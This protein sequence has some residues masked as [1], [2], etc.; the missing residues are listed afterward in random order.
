[1]KNPFIDMPYLPEFDRM[2]PEA[3][4]EAFA[5]LIP[6]TS[7]KFDEMEK[8]FTP[9]W[10]GLIQRL[11][12]ITDPLGMAWSMFQHLKSVVDNDGW[13]E[14]DTTFRPQIIE[15]YQKISQ[16]QALYNGYLTLQEADRKG[17]TLNATRRRILGKAI[18]DAE[19]SGVGLPPDKQARMNEVSLK[20]STCS[21]TFSNHVLDATKAFSLTVTDPAIVEGLPESLKAIT[22]Q[23]AAEEGQAGD[24][25]KGPWKITLDG[26]VMRPFM[27]YCRDRD[28]REKIL[29]AAATR[30]SSGEL[31]NSGL[32]E[33][34]IKLRTEEAQILGFPNYAALNLS[35]KMAKNVETVDKLI[36]DLADASQEA[37]N[38]ETDELT[39]FAQANGFPEKEL[40]NWDMAYWAERQRETLYAY[41]EEE[42]SRYFPLPHVL[43][44]L[45]QLAERLFNIRISQADGE[46][47]VW[48][49]DVHFFRVADHDGT[50]LA[51]FYLDPY[52]RPESKL[53]GAW[54]NE[55]RSRERKPDGSLVLPMCVLVC[56]Q[57]VPVGDAPAVM[58]FEEVNTLFHEFG[59][60]LQVMLTTVDERAAS[61]INGVEWDAVE[62][63][64][65]FMENWC[66]DRNT[67]NQLSQHIDTGASLPDDLYRK[68]VAGKNYRAASAMIR[69]LVFGATDMD[70]FARYPRPEW[71]DANAVKVA[72]NK[73][74]N[75]R[76]TLP[77]DR[78]LCTFTHIF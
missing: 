38:R 55:F 52:S 67:L 24:P 20:L 22:A 2:T 56:N 3:A 17:D 23:A 62:I 73:R 63:A 11:A 74:F 49:P 26:A 33:E 32:I 1:M 46:A 64:S 50:P 78:F 19:L 28:T 10:D 5:V 29:R 18:R 69:Q 60:A 42:L 15:L 59:H 47:P 21:N 14:V 44:G 8:A 53:G 30:A 54:M 12:D 51:C 34:I 40:K 6:E 66:Y 58:R 75:V 68:I 36:R 72:V 41:S 65:Q 7:R 61:G 48:H 27:M 43:K 31:D 13:R 77:E 45:F 70:L 4:K 35:T 76:P 16:S 25:A 57:T 37:A 9:T 71:K 39:A